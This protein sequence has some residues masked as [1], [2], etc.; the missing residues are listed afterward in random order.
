MATRT[1]HRSTA[2]KK[3]YAVRDANGRFKDIQTY[4]R[5]HRADLAKTSKAEIGRRPKNSYPHAERTSLRCS[6]SAHLRF[7][8]GLSGAANGDQ[9]SGY[10][11]HSG[12]LRA[13]TLLESRRSV[14]AAKLAR[15]QLIWQYCSSTTRTSDAVPNRSHVRSWRRLR[16]VMAPAGLQVGSKN[17]LV[18]QRRTH[19]AR[20]LVSSY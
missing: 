17:G 6:S 18:P 3:L 13:N 8:L 10:A 19:R 20:T 2:G 11:F 12:Y 4:E 9:R 5:A 15:Y 1:T 14:S 16:A 7:G